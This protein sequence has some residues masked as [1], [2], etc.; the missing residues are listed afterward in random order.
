MPS[1]H[2]SVLLSHESDA[3]WVVGGV[4][5]ITNCELY[6]ACTLSS[7]HSHLTIYALPT[8]TAA[9]LQAKV[10]NREVY[11]LPPLPSTHSLYITLLQL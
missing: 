11:V 9:C 6:H 4:H 3:I 1:Y 7:V 5:S 2:N 8:T 10:W